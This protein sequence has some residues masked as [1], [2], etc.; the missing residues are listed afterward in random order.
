MGIDPL[1][2]PHEHTT[3]DADPGAGPSR[4]RFLAGV[5]AGSAA[6]AVGSQLALG[7]VL[8]VG[9]QEEEFEPSEDEVQILFLAGLE[10]AMAQAYRQAA[11]TSGLAEATVTVLRSFG[12]HHSRAAASLNALLTDV[13][14]AVEFPNQTLLAEATA[15]LTGLTDQAQVTTALADLEERLAATYLAAMGRIE[16]ITDANRVSALAGV[17]GRHVVVLRS[18]ADPAVDPAE[19]VPATQTTEG[20]FTIAEYPQGEEPAAEEGTEGTDETDATTEGEG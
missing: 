12:T 10:L 20:A 1:R 15:T 8:P 19:L 13:I 6:V 2:R 14:P 7:N 17:P 5:A 4:R 3:T 11:Q 16:V 18:I 9:A